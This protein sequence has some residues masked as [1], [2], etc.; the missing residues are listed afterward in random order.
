MKNIVITCIKDGRSD[1]RGNPLVSGN[2]YTIE[3]PLAK[4]LWQS[5]FASVLDSSVFVD[6][7]FAG[8]D[9]IDDFLIA[10]ELLVDR[11]PAG[12]IASFLREKQAS[13]E[14]TPQ[15]T[16]TISPPITSPSIVLGAQA[17]II[18]SSQESYRGELMW[19]LVVSASGTSTNYVEV[20]GTSNE[21][22]T[23]RSATLRFAS[24][25]ITKIDKIGIFAGIDAAYSV[26]CRASTNVTAPAATRGTIMNGMT[27]LQ[28]SNEDWIKSGYSGET[29]D[30]V[31]TDTKVRFTIVN[32][33]TATIFLRSLS[34]G[35]STVGRLAIIADDGY[36][37]WFQRG[38]PI[39]AQ[40]G[41]KSSAAIIP[42]NV[43]SSEYS[44]VDALKSYVA[45]GNECIA[46]GCNTV[47]R[48]LN[49]F[50]NPS[51]LPDNAAR[52]ADVKKSTDFLRANK[53]CSDRGL[54]CYVWPQGAY[55]ASTTDLSF[56]DD[57]YAAGYRLGRATKSG[58][59]MYQRR[60][61]VSEANPNHFCHHVVGHT[62]VDAPSEAANIASVI[63]NIQNCAA[64][65]LDSVLMLHRI[66]GE[67]Q[68]TLGTHMSTVNLR[69]I[70]AAI[71]TLKQA[72]T[73]KD[74]LFSDFLIRQ[75]T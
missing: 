72:G 25:D 49:L 13:S 66:V 6:D 33:Q 24:P 48:G 67:G 53:L 68:E 37:S 22:F 40:Y 28:I 4:S 32:S 20:K 55:S 18:S 23:M 26:Y 44:D 43:G 63:T 58:E 27:S 75:D 21:G 30:L 69:S 14:K 31:I 3:E 35:G 15:P 2:E 61:L 38:V 62:F 71:S 52:M 11:N 39:L 64:Y 51:E 70:C 17:T 1:A 8:T 54:Q 36:K 34:F 50:T 46:H 29:A 12:V 16:T 59:F 10:R 7:P 42:Y 73:L 56:L 19:K 57:M 5:G 60:A 9:Q 45:A 65:G 47:T 41:I 74:V